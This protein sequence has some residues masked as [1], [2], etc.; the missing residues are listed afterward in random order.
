[1]WRA[2]GKELYYLSPD[3]KLMAVAVNAG[4][5][6][7]AGVP[8]ALFAITATQDGW[9]RYAAAPDGQRF[10]VISP[11]RGGPPPPTTVVLNWDAA[12]GKK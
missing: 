9:V 7:E 1:M 11:E 5:S 4:A 8:V 12:I 3:S 10:L 2:D 6:F